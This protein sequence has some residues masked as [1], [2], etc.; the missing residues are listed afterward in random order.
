MKQPLKT[1]IVTVAFSSLLV[2]IGVIHTMLVAK[3]GN[4]VTALLIFALLFLLLWLVVHIIMGA[5]K[6]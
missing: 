4:I 2:L 1:F 5:L 6:L 3:Y